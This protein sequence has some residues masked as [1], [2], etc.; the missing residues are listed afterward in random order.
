MAHD[1]G[2]TAITVHGALAANS[3]IAVAKF[4]AEIFTGS[5]SMLSEAFH[6]VV[7]TGNQGLLLLGMKR[8]RKPANAPHT[9]GYGKELYFW[10]TRPARS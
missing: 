7:D 2:G 6:S 8:S 3:V 1:V 10:S 9:F 5:A 4:A